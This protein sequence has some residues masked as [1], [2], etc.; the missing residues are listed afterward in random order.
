MTSVTECGALAI[1]GDIWASQ[2]E[3]SSTCENIVELVVYSDE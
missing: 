2:G 1:M 3:T